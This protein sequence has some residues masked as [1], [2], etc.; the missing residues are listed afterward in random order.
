MIAHCDVPS[1]T[2][3]VHDKAGQSD[4]SALDPQGGD[5]AQPG[6]TECAAFGEGDAS[7]PYAITSKSETNLANR[8]VDFRCERV[9]VEKIT[10]KW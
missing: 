9:A 3:N 8:L 5:L 6:Q 2:L 4:H 7:H 10:A 1:Q